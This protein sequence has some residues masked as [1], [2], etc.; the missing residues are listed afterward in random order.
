MKYAIVILGGAA[1]QPAQALADQ[2]PLQAAQAPALSRMGRVG[3]LGQVQ[4]LPETVE[5][6]PDAA[7]LALLGYDPAKRYTG[8]APLAAHGLGIELPDRAW[9]MNLSLI[10]APTGRLDVFDDEALPAAEARSIVQAMLPAIDLPGSVVHPG[11]AAM[12]LLIDLGRDDQLDDASPYRD[13]SPVVSAPPA[14]IRGQGIRDHLPVGDVPGERLQQLIAAS[15]VALDGHEIN[16]A[17]DEMQEPP[18]THLW[19]WGLGQTP[20]LRPWSDRFGQSAVLLSADPAMRGV[21]KCAGIDAIEPLT[22]ETVEGALIRLS[23]DAVDAISRYDLVIAH[24]DAPERAGL[25]GSV[26]DKAH[27]IGLIDEHL[28]KPIAQALSARGEHRLMATPLYATLA[29]QRAADPMP[30]PFVITGYKMAGVV[31]RPFTEAAAEACDL[32]VPFGYELMEFFL[33]SGVR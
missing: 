3:R 11:P 20:R 13:W 12:H 10:S 25:D 21:A 2:T 19:P 23:T 28:I 33:K 31:E 1:D 24:T 27:A 8:P 17:R 22:G 4:V 16:I 29:D 7:L 5:P 15:S 18:I 9:A 6:G 26:T 32:Q 14:V 30:V